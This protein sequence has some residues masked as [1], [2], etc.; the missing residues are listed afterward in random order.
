MGETIGGGLL[1]TPWL[2]GIKYP[3]Q[4][5]LCDTNTLLLLILVIIIDTSFLSQKKLSGI[6]NQKKFKLVGWSNSEVLG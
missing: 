3:K 1:L 6:T 5:T 2:I 4:I